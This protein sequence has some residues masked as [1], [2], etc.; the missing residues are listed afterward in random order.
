MALSR[1]PRTEALPSVGLIDI[2]VLNTVF[3]PSCPRADVF[4][5]VAVK[6]SGHHQIL[7]KALRASEVTEIACYFGKYQLHTS[8]NI[9]WPGEARCF[10]VT[11]S[12]LRKMCHCAQIVCFLSRRTSQVATIQ[13][14]GGKHLSW[15]LWGTKGNIVPVICGTLGGGDVGVSGLLF[16]SL[17]TRELIY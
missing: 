2:F 7:C 16:Y 6:S 12:A 15:L 5:W 17:V 13:N 11:R 8:K 14:Q 1:L 9:K 4:H 3:F 10:R